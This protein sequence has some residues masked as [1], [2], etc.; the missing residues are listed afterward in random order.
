MDLISEVWNSAQPTQPRF[1]CLEQ[2]L[3]IASALQAELH[4]R[5]TRLS[6]QTERVTWHHS[7]PPCKPEEVT[8]SGAATENDLPRKAFHGQQSPPVQ[9]QVLSVP[10]VQEVI[11]LT[12]SKSLEGIILDMRTRPRESLSLLRV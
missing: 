2:S 7:R 3:R 8:A 5:H 9:P 6:E 1:V 12:T 11:R 4:L 10:T